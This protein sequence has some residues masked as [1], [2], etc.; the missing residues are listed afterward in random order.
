[1]KVLVS[2][3][4]FRS[5]PGGVVENTEAI[6]SRVRR[7]EDR[8]R[9]CLP[10]FVL[11]P[12][13]S[14]TGPLTGPLIGPLGPG[15]HRLDALLKECRDA[16]SALAG[17]TAEMPRLAVLAGGPVE[18][19]GARYVGHTAF[20]GGS[21][22]HTRLKTVLGP[23]E[24]E[25][26]RPAGTAGTPSGTG[27]RTARAAV[28]ADS[29][30]VPRHSEA[31]AEL[32]GGTAELFGVRFGVQLCLETHL[33]EIAL[34][35]ADEGARIIFCGFASPR[36]RPREKHRRL[37]RYLPARGYDTACFVVWCNLIFRDSKGR[38]S[39]GTAGIIDPKGRLTASRVSR[40]ES[41]LQGIINLDE[42]ERIRASRMGYFR[43][44]AGGS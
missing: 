1:M 27:L 37:L 33:P 25:V 29:P 12:E 19:E 6:L 36:E 28:S 7:L 38:F 18:Q 30:G 34:R 24:K 26:F 21:A 5:I 40:G 32:A 41:H 17:A 3:V 4:N 11:F 15:I 16:H 14:L 31:G 35:Q 23:G 2:A 9:G 8:N 10:H 43:G 39:P 42:I 22:V 13:M 44:M 20:A